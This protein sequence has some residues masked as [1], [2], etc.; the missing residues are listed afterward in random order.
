MVDTRKPTRLRKAALL[1]SRAIKKHR[2]VC[3]RESRGDSV[4]HPPHRDQV[5][6]PPGGS[7]SFSAASGA[8]KRQVPAED[9]PP[10]LSLAGPASACVGAC[11]ASPGGNAALGFRGNRAACICSAG[12]VCL[13][14][15]GAARRGRT[16]SLLLLTRNSLAQKSSR[17]RKGT[18][19]LQPRRRHV[20][21]DALPRGQR[22]TGTRPPEAGGRPAKSLRGCRSLKSAH[23]YGSSG[24]PCRGPEQDTWSEIPKRALSLHCRLIPRLAEASR[25]TEVGPQH[26]L[27]QSA[28]T[29]FLPLF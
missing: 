28:E 12:C 29:V 21:A 1:R 5:C 23:A 27:S 8:G 10:G 9:Q 3:Q 14:L 13:K 25:R 15:S 18:S 11:P 16:G 4:T 26:R 24:K 7:Q 20:T 6:W 17:Y 2:G 19:S 22:A